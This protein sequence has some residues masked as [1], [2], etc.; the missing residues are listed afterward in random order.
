MGSI[1]N[2]MTVLEE[3]LP[4][5]VELAFAG[6]TGTFNMCNPGT[7]SHNELLSMYKEIVDQ[8]FQWKNFESEAE[9][10]KVISSE[11]SNNR[12]VT[13]KLEEKFPRLRPIKEAVRNTLLQMKQ[14]KSVE[15]AWDKNN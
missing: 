14:M 11:R 4:I 13:T 9:L 7:I 10:M 1:P 12:L 6:E 3:I 8:N 5:I 2:S 15:R